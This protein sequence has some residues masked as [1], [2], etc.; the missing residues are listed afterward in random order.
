MGALSLLMFEIRSLWLKYGLLLLIVPVVFVGPYLLASPSAQAGGWVEGLELDLSLYL[1]FVQIFLIPMIFVYICAYE[2]NPERMALYLTRP[3]RKWQLLLA[4]FGVL[5]MLFAVSTAIANYLFFY[6]WFSVYQPHYPTL[7]WQHLVFP[8]NTLLLVFL[9]LYVIG[10]AY[11]MFLV[12]ISP[13]ETQKASP[14][15]AIIVYIFVDLVYI[16]QSPPFSA[17]HLLAPLYY[18]DRIYGWMMSRLTGTQPDPLGPIGDPLTAVSA[19]LVYFAALVV[20]S[21]LVFERR[22]VI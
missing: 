7:G 20:V 1:G 6:A 8:A 21:M 5:F 10:C 9:T 15:V 11:S 14:I 4:R 19:L 22:D 18:D 2:V 17:I 16:F 12:M 3:V 13:T